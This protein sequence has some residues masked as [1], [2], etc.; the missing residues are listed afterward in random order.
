MPIRLIIA[1]DHDLLREG[2]KARLADLERFD[3]VGE[4]ADGQQAVDLYKEL[5]PDILL[6]DIS[7]PN[8]NGLE[9][10][11]EVMAHD[12]DAKVIIL[13]VYNDPQYVKESIR[14]GAKGFVL[15]DVCKSKMINA[16][17]QVA[18]GGRYLCPPLRS[19]DEKN[20]VDFNLTKREADVLLR[21]AQGYSNKEIAEQLSLSVRTIESHRS[22]IRDKTGGGNSA[23]LAN[24]AGEMGLV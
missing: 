14:I 20:G 10:T 7:M 16:I 1:D 12:P 23:S 9:A 4:A 22:S 21:I 11:K 18:G 6:T 17:T 8:K 13:S 2:I 24:I 15:K 5:N 19:I 3:I